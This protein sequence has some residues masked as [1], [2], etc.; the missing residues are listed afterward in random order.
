MRRYP[1]CRGRRRFFPFHHNGVSHSF[2]LNPSS[3]LLLLSS[4]PSSSSESVLLVW[5]CDDARFIGMSMRWCWIYTLYSMSKLTYYNK[6]R[7]YY[8]RW[9]TMSL[10]G[11]WARDIHYRVVKITI[12]AL[13]VKRI[14]GITWRVVGRGHAVIHAFFRF[15]REKNSRREILTLLCAVVVVV[16]VVAVVVVV[17]VVV[18]KTTRITCML[19]TITRRARTR[20]RKYVCMCFCR[21]LCVAREPY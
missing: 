7:R 13:N 17:I 9:R 14:T 5:A 4:S 8:K 20:M 2:S 18:V 6:T 15:S 16:V 1:R 12:A 19:K 10:T 3:S 11:F 21:Y